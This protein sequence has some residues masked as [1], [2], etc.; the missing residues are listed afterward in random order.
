MRIPDAEFEA[1]MTRAAKEGAIQS[2]RCR[3]AHDA[4]VLQSHDSVG[5][6]KNTIVVGDHD[7]RCAP[8]MPQPF[9]NS[10]HGRAA[11]A[12]QRRGRLVRKDHLGVADQRAGHRDALFLPAGQV[13]G[14]IFDPVGEAQQR[15]RGRPAA[16]GRRP[17]R[18]TCTPIIT[19]CSAVRLSCRL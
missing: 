16:P 17:R 3:I 19:F 9:E 18:S 1:I 7:G 4:P 2:S 5:K 6:V 14:Q 8:H 13:G 10:D 15:Q 12:I 11:F